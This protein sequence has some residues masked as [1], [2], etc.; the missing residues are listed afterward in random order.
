MPTRD[1]DDSATLPMWRG[2]R[3]IVALVVC[4]TLALLAAVA[5]MKF[6]ERVGVVP[7]C[8]A[9][10]KANGLHYRSFRE[11]EGSLGAGATCEFTEANGGRTSVQ[12]RDISFLE[13]LWVGLAL[14]LELTVPVLTL[15]FALLR[16][17]LFRS[18][19]VAR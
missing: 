6:A 7:T 17:W 9:Y 10:G 12:L 2:R 19:G 5:F 3:G 18:A 14:T 11:Y 15:L 16:T 1:A 4:G 8:V 13:D